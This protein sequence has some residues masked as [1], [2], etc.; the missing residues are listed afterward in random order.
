MGGTTAA[1]N[2]LKFL[3]YEISQINT[4]NVGIDPYKSRDVYALIPT[5]EVFISY[6]KRIQI[7][8]GVDVQHTHLN[9][10]GVQLQV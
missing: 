5:F 8:A 2:S 9:F 3:Q 1:E 6:L 10:S 4:S 7:E